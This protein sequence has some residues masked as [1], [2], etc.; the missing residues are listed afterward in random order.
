[1]WRILT[2]VFLV[3]IGFQSCAE[4]VF[5]AEPTT[6]ELVFSRDT[7]YLDT[8]FS[9]ISSS[10]R[11]FKVYNQSNNFLRIPTVKLAN[12][13]ESFYRLNVNGQSGKSFENIEILPK[14]SIY[15]FVE[16]TIDFSK[17]SDP[18]YEDEIVFDQGEIVQEVQLVT[19]VQDAYFLFPK[20]DENGIKE[21][22]VWGVDDNGDEIRVEGFYLEQNAVWGNDKPYVI[23]GYA[24]VNIGNTL[25]IERGAQIHF[26]ENSGLLVEKNASLKIEGT[27]DQKVVIQGDRL[28]PF[29]EN[30]AGQWGTIWLKAG[31]KENRINHALIKNNIIGILMDSIGSKSEPSLQIDNTEIYNTSNFGL[32]GRSA[33]INGSNV[34][35]G[36]NGQSSLACT[37]GGTYNFKHSTFGNFWSEGI[38]ELPAVLVNNFQQTGANGGSSVTVPNDLLAAN[39]TSCIIEGNQN[40]EFIL[41]KDDRAAFNFKFKNSLLRFID[42]GSA[43]GDP[44]YDFEDTSIYEDNILNGEAD[45]KNVDL[46]QLMIGENSDCINMADI[47]AAQEVPFDLLG[48]YR[49]ESPD[50]GAYQHMIFEP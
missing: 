19:L 24:G 11:T 16:A 27:L 1:M 36:N 28:E 25:K 6:G 47:Q 31:S 45:F 46:N 35:I 21:T 2:L 33:N 48:M 17:V 10:T 23:Y 15:I 42:N 34:V 49:I 29:Y 32:L 40:I 43:A 44:L 22:I 37:A 20:R 8:V 7:V 5:E 50:I 30:I 13:P 9:N 18:L 4:D 39:F 26:H 12:G 38:R 14:D 3:V 41:Q